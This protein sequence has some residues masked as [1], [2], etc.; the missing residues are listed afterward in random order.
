[1]SSA[2]TSPVNATLSSPPAAVPA[3]L[4]A[5]SSV[6]TLWMAADVVWALFLVLLA[7]SLL[8]SLRLDWLRVWWLD[9]WRTLSTADT[10]DDPLTD[11]VS[12]PRSTS[13]SHSRP[14]SDSARKREGPPRP[15]RPAHQP[16]RPMP[17]LSAAHRSDRVHGSVISP[18]GTA[19]RP[20]FHRSGRRH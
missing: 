12:L 15:L 10:P 1:M 14:S 9:Q 11:A 3:A 7:L 20:L 18:A 16:L 4:A 19:Q 2:L 13:P 6:H 5:D 17:F 8:V